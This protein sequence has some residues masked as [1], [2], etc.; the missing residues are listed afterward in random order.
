MK[1]GIYNE[2]T[3]RVD[4]VLDTDTYNEIDDQF[5]LSY[6]ALSP[7]QVSL[8]A[9]Y[10]APFLNE[11]STGPADG[12]EKSYQ[13]ILKLL[14]LL[15]REE[16]KQS[17]FRG[18]DRYLTDEVTPVW[19]DA[20]RDLIERS[21]AYSAEN[22]L[23]VVAIGAITNI[24]SA[25]IAD[26]TLKERIVV[27][28]LGGHAYHW[29]NTYEFNMFQDVAAARVVFLSGVP[30]VQL[31]CM[32][33]VTEFRIS[34]PELD[35][36]L[37]GANPL[38]DYLATHTKEAVK[39]YTDQPVWSR[40]IWDVTAAGYVI[41]PS[42]FTSKAVPRPIPEYDHTYTFTEEGVPLR[43][44]YEIKRDELMTDLVAKLRNMNK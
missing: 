3:G 4:V 39:E 7:E 1:Y 42:F 12:M 25:L 28:W 24:A 6:L 38:C 44:V 26:P 31:P 36:F 18:S 20:M 14:T 23:Y 22:P 37:M 30:L 33:V 29:P 17:T 9:V 2:P 10:A 32:G 11:R 15:Q 16:L 27:V 5:A 19:S 13:E 41:N 35:A 40:V 8:K 21:K 43:Y 34:G